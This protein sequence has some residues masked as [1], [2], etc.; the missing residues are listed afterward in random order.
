MRSIIYLAVTA[1][2]A[3][4]AAQSNGNPFNVPSDG[5]Q[6]VA[7]QPTTVTW[8]P[9]TPGTVSLRLQM[10]DNVT[11][12]DGIPLAENLPNSGSFEFTPPADIPTA[13]TYYLQI[14]D[15]DHPENSNYS[16]MFSIGGT[17]GTGTA[18]TP[19]STTATETRTTDTSDSSSATTTTATTDSAST[20]MTTSA[21]T[22]T[23]SSSSSSASSSSTPS[24]TGDATN[25]PDPNSAMSIA[26][27]GFMLSAVLALMSFL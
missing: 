20:T 18:L 7:G 22:T 10:G 14:M 23:S 2:A 17:T 16:P 13:S 15:D 11:P 12:Q 5:Y 3:V 4:V 24:P 27:P 9:T 1:F 26:R 19:I 6:F 21:S 8:D 25:A